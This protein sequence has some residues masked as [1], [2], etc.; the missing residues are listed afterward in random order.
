MT[1]TA[2]NATKTYDGV[3]FNGGNGVTYAGFVAGEGVGDLDGALSYGGT[4]QGA[5]NAGSYA[6]TAGGLTSGNYAISYVG[7]TLSIDRKALTITA[8]DATKTYDGQSFT[9]GAG[10]TY[11]GFVAG[12]D[13]AD[14]GGTLSYGGTAQGAVNAGNYTITAGGLTSGNYAISYVGG[15]LSIDRKALTV[16]ASDATKTYDGQAFTG[17]AGV[18]YAGFVAGEGVGDLGGTLSYGGTAQGAVNAGSYTITA[19][20]LN[21]GNYA[22]SYVDG[23]LIVDRKALTV[24]AANATKTYDGV[25][26]NGGDG[27][28]YAGFVA[29]EGVGD[30]G[31]AL[32]YGGTAQGAVNAGSYTITA[33]GLNSGNYAI[34]YVDGTLI[35]DRKALTVTAAN[36]TKTYDGVAF[37]GGNGVTYAGF[38]AGEGVG[39]L[40]GALSYGGTAQGAVNAGSY[41]I[42]AG[43]LSSGNYAI[44]YVGGT[45]SID[46]KA[47]TITA[48]N[49]TK[50]YDG[51]AFTGGAGVTYAGFVA[52]EDA[53]DLGGT[54]SYGGTAQGAVNAGSYTITAG[55]LTSG[56]YAISYV[57]GT[58]S[59]DRK[60]LTIT[61]SNATKTY[62]GVAFNG[63]NGVTYAGFVAG[64]GVGDLGG[65]LSYGGTAQGAVNA[66]NYTITAGGLTSGNYAISYVGGTL[67]VD[68]KALTITAS[69]ATK[70]YDGV[71]F[72]GGNGVTYAGFVAGEDAGDFGGALSYGGTAQGAV[73]AGSY[74]I[75][76]GG[77]SSGNYA[78][79]YV[80]GT[81]NVDRKALTVTASDATKTYDGVAFTGGA[82]V[83]Y[84]GFAAGEDAGDLGGT[85]SYGG[86]AQG[87]VNAGSYT[88]TAGGLN[89]S[90]Y[91]ISYVA[92]SLTVNQAALTVTAANATKTYDGQSFT[93]GAGV[94][95]AGFVAGEDA[96]DLGGTLSYGGTAQGAVNA[97]SYTITAGG[98]SSGNYA[99]SYV[100]GTLNVDR[101]ALTV[102]A[103]NATKTYDGVAFT[104]GAGVTYAG[105]VAGEDAGDLGGTLSYG[106]TA[107]GAVNAGSYTITAGGLSSGNY[108][109]SYVA[110]S[111]TVDQAALTVTAANATKTYDGQSFTGGAGV[112]YAGF[113]AG[114][115]AGD[116]G[117]T[118]SYGGTA[119]G[120]VNAGSYTIT[121]GGLSSGNY[122]ISYVG[123]TLNV[124]RK[125]LTITASN[126]TKTYDGVAFTGGNGVTYA[127]F[128]AGEDAGDVGG[129]LSYGGTAQGA[130]N[131]GSYTITAGGLSSG[132]YAI[133]YVAG[134][135][136]V[137][138]A[139]LTVTAANATKTYDGVA[140]NGGAGV[141]YAGFVA[142]EDAGDLGGTLSYGGTAQGAV[143]AGS[144]TITAGGLSSGN[145]AISYVAGNLTVNQAA[146]TVTAAN[147]TKTYDGV[148]F[149][150]GNGVTYAGFVAGEDAGDLGGT[151]S[152]GGTAQGAVNAGSYTIT[153]GGLSSGN[154]AISYVGG[155]LNVDRKALTVTAANATKTY[156]GVAFNGG[157][158]VTYAGFVAGEGVGDLGGTLSYGGTAQGAVNAGSYTI[159]AGGLTSGNYA[160]SYVS[161]T[162]SID[163]KALT[164][165]ASNATKTYDGQA[166][167]GGNGVTYAG[168]V[169]G[170]GVG[171][172]GGAL[173][174]GGTAQGAVNAGNYTITA[175]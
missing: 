140:F 143:N 34:S 75:T 5:V 70:T 63:G 27:V 170:E 19:G 61:A 122:A 118:L 62:D 104:G 32:S 79:S 155:T 17:G 147:A 71:A 88:I 102:T 82:G 173:S 89:S 138:Q 50:T 120:A 174:Y 131:A 108:A 121:A 114:E 105:F 123:G 49:A 7:G 175:G 30:L 137:D 129:A 161:G 157:N 64:E 80:G 73:N 125:A 135:L 20:G 164:I 51:V 124:D 87:A 56:N 132:N 66:G 43:G 167:T 3:A 40:D 139:A 12:E 148:A 45:L 72:T 26:F 106:G 76:A 149:N 141:T 2:A 162:L 33:G 86:T 31:G 41:A 156:D 28:T 91:A 109:I 8:S 150:G 90:N 9:G 23:T 130:V 95:Y 136:T 154:Y 113:V 38:V 16:T 142:G 103:A 94:T 18:T 14:L 96:G 48:S 46:R 25:A 153:A 101:K 53:G 117:G 22:I 119:Q 77:L 166:F 47:L 10:V 37:N 151:L 169:A 15:T 74:T 163:R 134:S 69:N 59:I 39:D 160:I 97:G 42:T 44:S 144:Y 84:T 36:A 29:G 159:T 93:G 21:S 110:G 92:G 99:I 158:G 126:A 85:L 172:L 6:I 65:A 100:G 57:S 11:A 83:T 128:V 152:Y 52:G 58:L 146:L 55:G 60:A 24:T 111:L 54:L 35:V 115:D 1:V 67:N 98:L 68:R 133:S 81:L 168:F 107:Q 171:D 116:V 112:T 78:I 4:A 13:A 127:G 145:Y 165:T